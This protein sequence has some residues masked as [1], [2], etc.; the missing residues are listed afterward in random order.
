ME[1][2]NKEKKIKQVLSDVNY[3]IDTDFLWKDVSQELDETKKRRRLWFIPFILLGGLGLAYL[4]SNYALTPKSEVSLLNTSAV[5]P[6]TESVNQNMNSEALVKQEQNQEKSMT[7]NNKDQTNILPT[8]QINKTK[9]QPKTTNNQ[10]EIRKIQTTNSSTNNTKANR[11]AL[12]NSA[13]SNQ[14][15]ITI[16][17]TGEIFKKPT[18]INASNLSKGLA[19]I[20]K[21]DKKEFITL[22][23]IQKL[24]SSTIAINNALTEINEEKLEM[25]DINKNVPN[26]W[27]VSIGAGAIQNITT[28]NTLNGEQLNG[29][30][31]KEVALPGISTTLQLGLQTK[32]N[33]RF[34]GGFDYAQLVTQYRN[35]DLESLAS[36]TEI[37]NQPSI[38]ANNNYAE[39][40]G[41]IV[42]ET[43]IENDI[44]WH[45]FQHSINL[46]LGLSKNI[47]AQSKF[48]IAPAF[49]V[50]QNINTI[51][52]GYYFKEQAPHF[53]KFEKNEKNPFR[54]NTGLKTQLAL[55]LGYRL[56][57]FDLSINTAWRNP[58]QSIT[59]QTNFYQTKNSQLSIQ[60]RVNY[61]LNWEH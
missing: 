30:F 50:L 27:F 43:F 25:I 33:W 36:S 3:D 17:N 48:M 40:S 29:Y 7:E 22:D 9:E 35:Q 21:D 23:G 4:T 49:S 6:I 41:N 61:L 12:T 5:N 55:N 51:H 47:F 8:N 31:D 42:T 14:E 13:N 44:Q 59:E 37:D 26:R 46:E 11:S 34:F 58:L 2:N 20:T 45:R 19:T 18:I 24:F 39:T 60:A 10:S 53:T 28:S 57:G 38:D 56:K 54:K 1:L 52:S 16:E 15:K 32:N